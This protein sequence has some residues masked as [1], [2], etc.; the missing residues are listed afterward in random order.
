MALPGLVAAKNLGDVADQERAWDNLGSSISA[1]FP[2]AFPSLDLDFA[3]NKNLID[4][5]SGNNLITFSRASTATFVDGAGVI[6]TAAS[7]VPRFDHNPETGE[8]LGLLIEES[9]TN[10][11]AWG[12]GR[13]LFTTR[14]CTVG[15]FTGSLVA[16]EVFTSSNGGTFRLIQYSGSIAFFIGIAGDQNLGN[17]PL[18][19]SSGT[20]TSASN[21]GSQNN[22]GDGPWINYSPPSII[23]LLGNTL[24]I[25]SGRFAC[26]T[27]KS[28]GLGC[29]A[30][31][32]IKTA[33][34]T[35]AKILLSQ[36]G[37]GDGDIYVTYTFSTNTFTNLE[38][39]GAG[40]AIYGVE[41]FADGWYRFYWGRSSMAGTG[42]SFFP[43]ALD[44]SGVEV[45]GGAYFDGGQIE[46]GSFPTSYI[47]T[48]G[49]QVTRAADVASI[50]GANFSSWY[51][52]SGGTIFAS[53]RT[54]VPANANN[55][56]LFYITD[57]TIENRIELGQGGSGDAFPRVLG[58][59]RFL[60]TTTAQFLNQDTGWNPDGAT[61]DNWALSFDF[62][63]FTL[64]T[65][66]DSTPSTG[67][68]VFPQN[69]TNISIGHTGTIAR[70]T[71][72]PVRL[73]NEALQ[74]ITSSSGSAS[75]T[76]YP[77]SFSVEGADVLALNSV[78]QTSTR[79]FVF[80]KGLTSA[81]QPRLTTAA[82]QT[83]SGTAL[84]DAA[85]LKASPM[86]IGNYLFSSGITLSGVSTRIN[87]TPALSI[88]TSPFSG[89]TATTSILL[90]ELQPQTNWRISEPMPSGTIASP[91]LAIPFETN[92]FVLFMKAGQS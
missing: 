70:F 82:Q 15:S 57:G 36:I 21:F 58:R 67:F 8:S 1:D 56:F 74:Y 24:D 2:I 85:M 91:D 25:T 48:A 53:V 68:G 11:L 33:V 37:G 51:N 80:L 46:V 50:T 59:F 18:I 39:S 19:A 73:R 66:F 20:I 72:Y 89:S 42:P 44:S 88:A 6:Q 64:Q 54:L 69:L 87:T 38:G 76:T 83:A 29:I 52:Q 40:N 30:S 86:T 5:V 79:D 55:G 31:I 27:E 34:P 41:K 23:S 77:Y 22:F 61:V 10:R 4:S 12:T 17:L 9:R 75:S 3:A 7:G 16:G 60:N 62:T 65:K 32:F 13:P 71:Y 45:N 49:S 81:A 63:G 35:V 28:S 78:R 47:P 26:G 14:F 90:R 92:D 84:Q 43:T